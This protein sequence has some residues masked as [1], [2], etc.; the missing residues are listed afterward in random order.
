MTLTLAA[1]TTVGAVASAVLQLVV[2]LTGTF[3][4]ITSGGDPSKVNAARN[5]L[6]GGL[7]S[8][9]LTEILLFVL[10]GIAWVDSPIRSPGS[11]LS[12][13]LE[14][15]GENIL[16]GAMIGLAP[17]TAVILAGVAWGIGRALVGWTQGKEAEIAGGLVGLAATAAGIHRDRYLEEFQSTLESI[18]GRLAAIRRVTCALSILFRAP[19]LWA[20][21]RFDPVH[22]RP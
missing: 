2:L 13:I 5:W 14:A 20:V 7:V 10:L 19:W 1:G 15:T 6:V 3:R 18:D 8:F 11:S 9:L 16:L 22:K 4:W 21:V 17:L 12:Y